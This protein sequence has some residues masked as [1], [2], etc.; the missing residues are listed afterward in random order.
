MRT[1]TRMLVLSALFAALTAVGAF[2]KIPV[3]V[4]SFTLQFLFTAL[5][6]VLLGPRYG[7]L[8]QA[9][10]VLLGLFGLPVFTMG[11]GPG[12][13]L[14]PT[15]GFLLGLIPAA[16]LA[17]KLAGEEARPRRVM[18]AAAAGLGAMYLVGIPYMYAVLNLYLGRGMTWGQVLM[19]GM[20]LFLPFDGLKIAAAGLL[21][22]P[23]LRALRR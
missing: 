18:A 12:Y 16:W 9:A 15:C 19:A 11:G 4:S 6:G 8:S 3:G 1:N 7:A 17:G 22:K 23:L 13:L 20:V 14:Q 5:A 10:Y 2:L 21:A